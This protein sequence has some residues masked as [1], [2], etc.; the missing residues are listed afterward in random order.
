MAELLKK[1]LKKRAIF[2]PGEQR[3]FLLKAIENLN[4]SW[5]LFSEKISVH[6]RTL[7]D[8]KRE[9]YSIPFNVLRK[10][11]VVAKVKIPENIE[12]R[13]PFWYINKGAKIGGIACIKKYGRVGGD[14]EYR[15]KRWYEWWEREGKYKPN[16]IVSCKPIRKPRYSRN[17]AEFVGI[18]LGDG[19]IS[20][21]QISISFNSE[22]EK[23][24]AKF[25]KSLIRRL[26]DVYVGTYYS[27]EYLNF[28]L[29][30]SRSKLIYFCIE[31]LGLK[32]GNKVRQQ[33]DIPEWIKQNKSYLIACVRGLMDTDG[34]A[35]THR[36]RVNGKLYSYKKLAFKNSSYPLIKS[37]YD[38]L[39]N[40]ILLR[41]R[42]SKDLKE[43]RIESKRDVQ[44]Y[45]QLI[46]F[47]NP[48]NLKRYKN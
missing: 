45:F 31:K 39:K 28:N 38:F 23:E 1:N 15:K 44:K 14:P 8:W 19:G 21:S 40:T 26:F 17:L 25:V 33:V 36:Y 4:L 29:L 37:V 7:N 16:T 41:P 47:H 46:G 43:V 27:K 9:E 20:K 11:S 2:P 32:R 10:I 30:I 35:F 12:V 48:K 5:L 3:R 34:C 13:E 6:K 42:I 22:D 18:V 24:Y